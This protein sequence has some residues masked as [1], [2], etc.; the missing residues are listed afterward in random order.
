VDLFD[1]LGDVPKIETR[2]EATVAADPL[3]EEIE[4]LRSRIAVHQDLYH[5]EDAPEI[6][7]EEYDGMVRRHDQIVAERPDLAS[8][9]S[10]TLNVGGQTSSKLAKVVH[11]V[12]MLSLD[13]A[14]S[15]ADVRDFDR[16]VSEHLGVPP[17][18][19]AYTAEPKDDGLSCSLTYEMGK[20]VLAATRGKNG[21]GEDVTAQ[22]RMVKEIPLT[23][24]G[25]HP[26][27]LEVRGEV[28]MSHASFKEIN[29]RFE[30][31]GRKPLANCRNGAAGALRQSDPEE[32]AQRPLSFLAYSAPQISGETPVT[33]TELDAKLR[34]WGFVTN[35][36]FKRCGDVDALLEHYALI[37]R[38]RRG[39]GY[40][41]D[42]VVY[43]VDDIALQNR[44][45]NIS[46]T[47]RWAI[48]HKFPSDRVQTRM[49]AI[50]IQVGRTGQLTPVARLSPVSVGGVVV[51]NATLH[52]EDYIRDGD[53][54]VG[55]IVVLQRAGDV[56]PQIVG[57]AD[58][59]GEDRAAR[60]PYAFPHECPECGAHAAREP[61]EA[62]RRCVAGLSC[63]AQRKERL[64]HL[65]SK[66]A[67]D[68]DGLGE[69][70]IVELV[71]CG[72]LHEPADIFRLK[73][74]RAEICARDGW[75]TS[76]VSK[77][78]DSIEARRSSPLDR[79]LYSFGIRHVGRT[80]TTLLARRF[81][82]MDAL[83]DVCSTLQEDRAHRRDVAKETGDYGRNRTG[84][85]DRQRFEEELAKEIA[86]RLDIAQIGP[87]IVTSLLDFLEDSQNQRMLADLRS[88]M[89]VQ[90]VVFE[91]KES[92]V[93]GLTVVFTGAL[94]RMGRDEAKKHAESIGAKVSGSISAKTSILVHGPGAGSK[95]AKAEGLGVRTMTEE[96]W[97]A[98]VE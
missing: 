20:L 1:F 81:H 31:T 3:R 37:G 77:M 39:L 80:A 53:Y 72:M 7:D 6:T 21:V 54:R 17:G 26:D 94:E 57:I 64:I 46:R 35:P 32:T 56:I 62:A 71:D 67:L 60:E 48:A 95:L 5:G 22:A 83:L 50:D 24:S 41:I 58:M 70:A 68:I 2:S 42:G 4:S 73:D 66:D 52:N 74:R 90:E 10:P 12:P 9:D 86:G 93:T 45:G 51:T 59:P 96:E 89:D 63:P 88:E 36:L 69:K 29:E 76:S 61:D 85:F 44:L 27:I 78:I 28:Y 43:K 49:T 84:A 11:K 75:G 47:P 40:D 38:E 98:F 18:T 87:E 33:Q 79:V 25:D 8:D 16:K 30:A 91:T 55:D 13:N 65:A 23:L 19:V 34:E 82:G 15:E 97:W 92:P 14:F